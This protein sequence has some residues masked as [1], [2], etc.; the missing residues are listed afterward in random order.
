MRVKS[1]PC[2]WAERHPRKVADFDSVEEGIV[3]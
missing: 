1:L 2:G 3:M